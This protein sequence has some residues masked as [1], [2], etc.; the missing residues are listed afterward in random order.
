[1]HDRKTV[2]DNYE[3]IVGYLK[4]LRNAPTDVIDEA[5]YQILKQTTGHPNPNNQL[6]GYNMLSI[7]GSVH[8][9]SE[10]LFYALINEMI[11]IIN[12]TENEDFRKALNYAIPRLCN[13]F[14]NRRYSLPSEEEIEAI[15]VFG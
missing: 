14:E 5:Y 2:K 9:P 11:L 3:L 7:L 13:T 10:E 1:M 15:E 12:S 6:R 4:I 8:A